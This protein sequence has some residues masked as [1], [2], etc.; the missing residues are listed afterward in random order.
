[1]ALAPAV[2]LVSVPLYAS[3]PSLAATPPPT[4]GALLGPSPVR[5]LVSVIMVPA[6]SMVSKFE[7][8]SIMRQL[9]SASCCPACPTRPRRPRI[10]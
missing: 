7:E 5:P 2:A 1:M 10:S 4:V 8:A 3:V 6:G 9:P